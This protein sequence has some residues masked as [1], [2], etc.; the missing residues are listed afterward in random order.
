MDL[1]A[2]ETKRRNIITVVMVHDI[3]IALKHA[4]HVLMLKQGNLIA[5]E[6][7]EVIPLK[8]S[9]EVYTRSYR[10]LFARCSASPNRWAG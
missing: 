3:N 8:A 4:E 2:K 5:R 9:A 10:T 1:V 7:A 6:P